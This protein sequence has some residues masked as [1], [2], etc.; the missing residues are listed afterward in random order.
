MYEFLSNNIT[1]NG[2]NK[3]Q[4]S[5]VNWLQN[6]KE[7]SEATKI[8]YWALINNHICYIEK[9]KDKDLYYFTNEEIEDMLNKNNNMKTTSILKSIISNYTNKSL[10]NIKLKSDI[11]YKMIDEFYKFVEN[12]KCSDIDKMILVL[13]R[14]GVSTQYICNIKWDQVDKDDM[15]LNISSNIKLPIDD[16]FIKCLEK[17]YNCNSYDYKTSTLNYIDKG[18]IIKVSD[19]SDSDILNINSLYTRIKAMSSNNGLKKISLRELNSL[20]KYDVLYN[21]LN[22]KGIVTYDDV[23]ETLVVLCG[24]STPSKEQYLKERFTS[25]V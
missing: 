11:Q 10:K 12:L 24:K 21:I 22:E 16:R 5:K 13:A 8:T 20:R 25:M 7:Y 19:K 15:T 3:Y 17:S 9:E 23:R 1:Y 6:N 4:Q 14:Y 2:L 18:Y